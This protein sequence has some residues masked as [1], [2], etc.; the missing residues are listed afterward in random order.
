MQTHRSGR[1]EA[2][3]G[4]FPGPV[5]PTFSNLSRRFADTEV[6]RQTKN[7][8]KGRETVPNPI[9]PHRTRRTQLGRS[10]TA[11]SYSTAASM[12][13]AIRKNV[14]F[15]S[16]R[17]P[18][19]WSHRD[20]HDYELIPREVMRVAFGV[21]LLYVGFL[22][23]RPRPERQAPRGG[24]ARRCWRRSPPPLPGQAGEAAA[25]GRRHRVSFIGK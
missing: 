5:L 9:A 23:V 25:A 6:L 12:P 1:A 20:T 11:T 13:T 19:G 17:R 15:S 7:R 10:E 21:M 3:S 2:D 8:R 14:H 24:T 16:V 22:F 18:I 4:R